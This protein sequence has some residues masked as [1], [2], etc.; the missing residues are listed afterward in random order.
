MPIVN[1][2]PKSPLRFLGNNKEQ[3][4]QLYI[5]DQTSFLS[6]EM[7]EDFNSVVQPDHWFGND[8]IEFQ[9]GYAKI[10]VPASKF[11]G[12]NSL[13]P[14]TV[15]SGGNALYV[16]ATSDFN[17]IARIGKLEIPNNYGDHS[18]FFAFGLYGNQEED[19]TSYATYHMRV[20]SPGNG[21]RRLQ[22]LWRTV[23]SG[24]TTIYTRTESVQ[25]EL[26]DSTI[27]SNLIVGTFVRNA[28]L[29]RV[30]NKLIFEWNFSIDGNDTTNSYAKN[31][32]RKIEYLIN[33]VP[34]AY[35]GGQNHKFILNQN[36][37]GKLM[38]LFNI[39]R[40]FNTVVPTYSCYIDRIDFLP[41][42]SIGNPFNPSDMRITKFTDNVIYGFVK[43]NTLNDGTVFVTFA[44]GTDVRKIAGTNIQFV[45]ENLPSHRTT[46]FMFDNFFSKAKTNDLNT[47]LFID[48]IIPKQNNQGNLYPNINISQQAVKLDKTY[49]LEICKYGTI[50]SNFF[51]DS[52]EQIT[53]F[54]NVNSIFNAK[55]SIGKNNLPMFTF[56][57]GTHIYGRNAQF[58]VNEQIILTASVGETPIRDE[59]KIFERDTT[60]L[61]VLETISDGTNFKVYT[62][63]YDFITKTLGTRTQVNTNTSVVISNN[64]YSNTAYSINLEFKFQRPQADLLVFP[65]KHIVIMNASYNPSDPRYVQRLIYESYD[66]GT[67]WSNHNADTMKYIRF[68]EVSLTPTIYEVDFQ[69]FKIPGND[70]YFFTA[71]VNNDSV[72]SL[73][74]LLLAKT[75][76]DNFET[77]DELMYGFEKFSKIKNDGT[78]Y[79]LNVSYDNVGKNILLA[80][81][82]ISTSKLEILRSPFIPNESLDNLQLDDAYGWISDHN[83]SSQ[84]GYN[85]KPHIATDSNGDIIGVVSNKL[86]STSFCIFRTTSNKSSMDLLGRFL[87]CSDKGS[88]RKDRFIGNMFTDFKGDIY[89]AT[90]AQGASSTETYLSVMKYGME[91]NEPLELDYDEGFIYPQ[92]ASVVSGSIS[93]D[94]TTSGGLLAVNTSIGCKNDSNI[95]HFS[96][97][98]GG[99]K[100]EWKSF[101][102]PIHFDTTSISARIEFLL[103]GNKVSATQWELGELNI[104]WDIT[105]IWA[106]SGTT[107]VGKAL[108]DGRIFRKYMYIAERTPDSSFRGRVFA[109]NEKL[110]DSN[111]IVWDKKID[112]VSPF[113]TALSNGTVLARTGANV[114]MHLQYL[115]ATRKN[116]PRQPNRR[117]RLQSPG[118]YGAFRSYSI[119]QLENYNGFSIYEDNTN[120]LHDGINV[121]WNGFEAIKGDKF[122][123]QIASSSRANYIFDKEP[124]RFWR[125]YTDSTQSIICFDA[126]DNGLYTIQADV[127]VFRNANFRRCFVEGANSSL[128]NQNSIPIYSKEIFFD[129]E[130]GLIDAENHSIL[131]YTGGYPTVISLS[132]PNKMWRINEHIGKFLQIE[133]CRYD[134]VIYRHPVFKIVGNTENSLLFYTGNKLTDLTNGM[135][136][137]I[138]DGNLSV[139]L[140]DCTLPLT[141]W[142]VRIP[143]SQLNSSPFVGDET[144]QGSILSERYF[145]LG[146]FDLGKISE[147]DNDINEDFDI[148]IVNNVVSVEMDN[149]NVLNFETARS[150]TVKK[151]KY[152][153]L[154]QNQG[155][156]LREMFIRVYG[157]KKPVWIFDDQKTSPRLFML[158]RIINEPN[159]EEV[160]D[161]IV[162]LSFDV[163]EIV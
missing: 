129:E 28:R 10:N 52:T 137:T 22:L 122:T 158:G 80:L 39:Q 51:K 138:F 115:F 98:H 57:D 67:T 110:S 118:E 27:I 61:Y 83:I 48:D 40:D 100:S 88:S 102:D 15:T 47:D 76:V 89:L 101:V 84:F 111:K 119:D 5:P 60:S 36:N 162:S 146:E 30:G 93:A 82:A 108:C 126:T 53:S 155:L 144:C 96:P 68:S 23:T 103:E 147:Y 42:V 91:T 94:T 123:F 6:G 59:Y 13:F 78:I 26:G 66:K 151:I 154:D 136:Y 3:F 133:V 109:E 90:S 79:R 55:N 81:T 95:Q 152:S 125:S 130:T 1:Y 85:G 21:L 20:D 56:D 128:L 45:K 8:D 29:A 132:D 135:R 121:S 120:R 44:D 25:G 73:N 160:N 18:S 24:D 74:R 157:S 70:Q 163:E 131:G 9:N 62:R 140:T 19:F 134:S 64:P 113:T 149:L 71:L 37:T 7:S 114:T 14:Y 156:K 142:R 33:S 99:F 116:A 150:R 31:F 46:Q 17:F 124:Y 104:G 69:S 143:A 54:N 87:Q 161:G 75:R 86:D 35:I 153:N 97:G 50:E 11:T 139:N 65:E 49:H 159:I 34:K 107:R 43:R 72:H 117:K 127:A 112:F 145:E 141:H 16:D 12:F 2:D 105:S 77:I 58:K 4:I 92:S 148:S 63:T 41:A 106:Y 38:P 32:T